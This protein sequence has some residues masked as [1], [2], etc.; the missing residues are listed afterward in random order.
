MPRNEIHEGDVGTVFELI[1]VEWDEDLEEDVVVDISTATV[2]S[3]K[4]GKPTAATVTQ[5]GVFVTDG[6]DGKMKYTSVADDL[7]P[8]GDWD[9]QGYVEMPAWTGHSDM[10][11]FTVHRNL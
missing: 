5:T 7:V 3:I 10:G 1:M 4:F 6:T 9:I 8:T 2:K 11:H